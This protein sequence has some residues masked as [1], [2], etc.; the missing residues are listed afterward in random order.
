MA[1]GLNKKSCCDM[2]RKVSLQI[3][4]VHSESECGVPDSVMAD[5][6]D[7]DY[8]SKS[9]LPVVACL[10]L[11]FCPWCGADRRNVPD[12]DRRTT[13]VTKIIERPD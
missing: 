2:R 6:H 10:T 1:D 3:A 4:N 5:F 13:E 11:R 8:E 9:G 12:S 7:F